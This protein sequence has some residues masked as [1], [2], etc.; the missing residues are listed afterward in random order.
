MASALRAADRQALMRSV[1]EGG[2]LARGGEAGVERHGDAPELH[3]VSVAQ[4]IH[5]ADPFAIGER[6]VERQAVVFDDPVSS[7]DDVVDGFGVTPR[8]IMTE[9]H[10]SIK[11]ACFVIVFSRVNS[12]SS[13]DSINPISFGSPAALYDQLPY[14]STLLASP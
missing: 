3:L 11:C 9:L 10:Q 13:T 7:L 1:R 2:R 5:P 8:Q 6:A 12:E 14:R 4:A